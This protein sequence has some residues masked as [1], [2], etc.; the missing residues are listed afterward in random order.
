MFVN[1][2]NDLNYDLMTSPFPIW[3]FWVKQSLVALNTFA[4]EHSYM[5]Q[6]KI[7]P[8]TDTQYDALNMESILIWT[9]LTL[10]FEIAQLNR[11]MVI[12]G[13]V[14]RLEQSQPGQ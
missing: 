2:V 4:Y 9:G 14:V 5:P 12:T 8:Q 7:G 11:Y 6:H 3:P 1:S 13:Q 10:I